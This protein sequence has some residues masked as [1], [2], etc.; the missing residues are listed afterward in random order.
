[1]YYKQIHQEAFTARE[2]E[3]AIEN[4]ERIKHTL[5]RRGATNT[6]V[7]C[8]SPGIPGTGHSE[9]YRIMTMAH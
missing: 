8:K 5:P 1:M 3:Q 2:R 4:G 6:Q 9:Q 7:S